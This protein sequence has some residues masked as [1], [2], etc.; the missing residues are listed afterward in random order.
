M[1]NQSALDTLFYHAHTHNGW[2][3]RP[4]SDEQLQQLYDALRWAPTAANGSPARL[5]FVRSAEAKAKLAPAL[6]E[7]NLAKTLAAPVTVIVGMD[8]EFY[9]KLPQL[10]PAVDA[11]S[12]FAGNDAAIQATAFRNSSLQG[13]YLI[14]AA[15]A[16]GLDVGPMSGFDA[17]KVDAAFFAGT[18]VKANF[19]CNI[20]YGDAAKIRPRAPRL[21]FEQ[22]CQIV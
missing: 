20:G 5:V 10:S 6:S 14:L 12:W 3:D 1:L 19:I 9:E 15:R 2:Q 8:M 11:R 16:L 22:A 17:A 21:S 7:G 13:G 4:V 18:P